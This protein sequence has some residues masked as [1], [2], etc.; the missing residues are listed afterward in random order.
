MVVLSW[1]NRLKLAKHAEPKPFSRSRQALSVYRKLTF[2]AQRLP[3]TSYCAAQLSGWG[4]RRL[5]VHNARLETD[6]KSPPPAGHLKSIVW[7][8]LELTSIV[9]PT[10]LSVGPVHAAWVYYGWCSLARD[11]YWPDDHF[12]IYNMIIWF[13]MPCQSFITYLISLPKKITYLISVLILSG[14]PLQGAVCNMLPCLMKYP[15]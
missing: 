2:S 14:A 9:G 3:S 1:T 6:A 13:W 7:K 11:N 4:A 10:M 15:F 12:F 5:D 8:I